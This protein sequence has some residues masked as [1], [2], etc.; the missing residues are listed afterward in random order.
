MNPNLGLEEQTE[1]HTLLART[2][3]HPDWR[4]ASFALDELMRRLLVL[5]RLLD[6]KER[7]A[8]PRTSK[9]SHRWHSQKLTS[10]TLLLALIWSFG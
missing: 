9:R 7:L 5:H 4:V 6:A 1:A 3:N 8:P 2:A 10:L